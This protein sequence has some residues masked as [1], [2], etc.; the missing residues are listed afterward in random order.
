[1]LLLASPPNPV[2]GIGNLTFNVMPWRRSLANNPADHSLSSSLWFWEMGT[3]I[4]NNKR[5]QKNLIKTD[6]CY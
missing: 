4:G 5:V 6:F 2:D 3:L 1:M